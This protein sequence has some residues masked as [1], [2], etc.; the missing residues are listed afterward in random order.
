MNSVDKQFFHSL[1]KISKQIMTYKQEQIK[2]MNKSIS[3]NHYIY[4]DVV[5][6]LIVPTNTEIAKT[7][8]ISN[9][10]VTSAMKKLIQQGLVKKI[11]LDE[12]KRVFRFK[13]TSSG[14]EACKIYEKAHTKF[15][16]D[17]KEKLDRSEYEK[18]TQLLSKLV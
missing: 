8:D 2:E 1:G 9:P 7:L 14:E 15:L 5:L 17:V 6:N 11:Q 12:D 10:A 3:L 18:L 4:L 16:E 13:L